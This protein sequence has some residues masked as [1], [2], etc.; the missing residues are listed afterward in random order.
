M[1]DSSMMRMECF[2]K[3]YCTL[4]D[5]RGKKRRVLDVGSYDVN[6][7][8]KPLFSEVGF[9]YVGLDI[10]DGPNVDVVPNDTYN[11]E[12]IE[13]QSFDYI[14]SG[15]AFE[16]IEYPW[17]TI[18]EM[19]KKL[20]NDGILC[21]IAPNGSSEHRHPVDCWRFFSD[22]MR[23]LASWCNLEVIEVSVGG[24]PDLYSPNEFDC[25][26]NDVCLVA[27][28]SVGIKNKYNN[29]RMFPIER[30]YDAYNDLKLQNEFLGEWKC[31]ETEIDQLIIENIKR[32]QYDFIYIA[33]QGYLANALFKLLTKQGIKYKFIENY[34]VISKEN[35]IEGEHILYITTEID[36]YRIINYQ[37]KKDTEYAAVQYLGYLV[38]EEAIYQWYLEN[39][40]F[41]SQCQKKYIYG[42]GFNGKRMAKI[43]DLA[44][45]P[46]S[47]FVVSDERKREMPLSGNI[48]SIS[49]ISNDSGIIVSPY[50][51]KEIYKILKNKRFSYVLNGVPIIE[52][53]SA[54]ALDRV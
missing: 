1:H 26:C 6:G 48:Y 24:V 17:L 32:N 38:Q 47:G 8:Y 9:E 53:A 7:T 11:W 15:Q 19:K 16:H 54:C 27:C 41:F 33:G 45:I 18:G 40:N 28:K 23:A 3:N 34:S 21:I 13:N 50:D 10:S 31:N 51:S 25:I 49:E 5:E 36:S 35:N 52:K 30:R 43:L 44:K 42:A 46:F 4:Y 22:G 14:V 39:K 37:I 12:E 2:I 20:K 29:R